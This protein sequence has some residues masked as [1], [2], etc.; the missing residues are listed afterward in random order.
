MHPTCH[1]KLS[2]SSVIPY[3]IAIKRFS[4][5]TKRAGDNKMSRKSDSVRRHL[6]LSL[7]VGSAL[8]GNA[9]PEGERERA[10]FLSSHQIGNEFR[11]PP[12]PVVLLLLPAQSKVKGTPKC[13]W[14]RAWAEQATTHTVAQQQPTTHPPMQGK[15]FNTLTSSPPSPLGTLLYT[16]HYWW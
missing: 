1:S 14:H 9:N 15:H 6:L 16:L 12:S 7:V 4:I 2:S 11:V 10:R 5:N 13:Q 8:W 3:E